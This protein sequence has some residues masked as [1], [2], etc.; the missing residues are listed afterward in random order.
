MAIGDVQRLND[1]EEARRDEEEKKLRA[2]DKRRMKKLT[3]MNL[4]LAIANTAAVNDPLMV[5]REGRRGCHLCFRLIVCARRG[6]CVGPPRGPVLLFPCIASFLSSPG[7]SHSAHRTH[8]SGQA[9]KRTKLNLPAPQVSDAEL[10]EIAKGGAAMAAGLEDDDMSSATKALVGVYGV[11]PAA[12]AAPARTPRLPAS[13]D[14]IM[15]EARNIL[16][17]NAAPTP[18]KV[19]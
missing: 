14:V 2:K 13:Q 3:A 5:R 4:P 12:S 17:L 11:T 9:R 15:E 7:V 18:L 8:S 16:A 1:V 6:E 10:A 19:G